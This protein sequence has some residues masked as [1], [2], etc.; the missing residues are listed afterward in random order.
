MVTTRR[1]VEAE[2][3]T[4]RERQAILDR[5]GCWFLTET[6]EKA[7]RSPSVLSRMYRLN[8]NW[9]DLGGLEFSA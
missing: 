2:E 6:T 3:T 7:Q 9:M 5:T 1:Y 4:V 8:S